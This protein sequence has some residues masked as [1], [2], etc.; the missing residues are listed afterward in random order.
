MELTC[1]SG[2]EREV[3]LEL[4]REAISASN[5]YT[6]VKNSLSVRDSAI[7]VNGQRIGE[8]R[9]V[10]MLAVGK[11][12]CGMSRAVMEILDVREGLIVTKRGY[13]EDCPRRRG[14][15][16]LEAGHPTPDAISIRAG[17]MGLKLARKADEG[18][19]LLVL[20]SGGGSS[21]FELPES[22]ISLEDIVKTNELLLRSG[23]RIQ[24]IN[25]VRKH[26]SRVK[27]GRLAMEVRGTVISLII[28]DVVGNRI[29]AVASGITAR[30][31]TT[32]K[33]AYEVLRRR[34][35]W[36]DLPESVRLHISR[37]LMGKARETLK[38]DLPNVH[39]FII[40]S[41]EK[42]CEVIARRGAEMGLNTAVLTTQLEGE[43]SEAGL[44]IGAI[45]REVAL[46]DRPVRKPALMV[47]G[48]ETT[49]T[50]GN[51][52]G[53]G[54]PNQELALSAARKIS[55]LPVVLVAFD[56][57]GTDGPTDAAGAVVDGCTLKELERA[58]V[59]V[60]GALREHDSYRAL[61]RIGA[62]LRTG[63]TGTNVNSMV[64]VMVGRP[65]AGPQDSPKQPKG[66]YT[67]TR[68]DHGARHGG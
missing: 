33:D 50:V 41:V 32:F 23:A 63:P 62:L 40:A 14:I 37:G 27:G 13:A 43:A 5:P 39:N 36:D 28:S 26:L 54:G 38:R 59:D 15:G 49:V 22:G 58:G 30:D 42:A 17:E 10:Y 34:G 9:N 44:V 2:S 65:N 31:P 20:I 57:D 51:A 53:T 47:L 16:V 64:L 3:L 45:A 19:V 67:L 61:D 48:G 29:D 66:S 56:T 68:T 4:V 11:A 1:G 8:F 35:V 12:A 52:E 46:A 25:T 6:A 7:Y 21:V 24:E 55:G 60:D 18:D